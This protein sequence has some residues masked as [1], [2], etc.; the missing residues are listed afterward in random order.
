M[1]VSGHS[2]LDPFSGLRLYMVLEKRFTSEF[3]EKWRQFEKHMTSVKV[4]AGDGDKQSTEGGKTKSEAKP[5]KID[6]NGTRENGKPATNDNGKKEKG[7]PDKPD[8]AGKPGKPGDKGGKH[9]KP[10][11]SGEAFLK[12]DD[13]KEANML[14]ARLLKHRVAAQNLVHMI[15]TQ[16]SYKW[17]DN[18]ANVGSLEDQLRLLDAALTEPMRE[19]LVQDMKHMMDKYTKQWPA[20]L[21]NFKKADMLLQNVVTETKRLL[22]G[23]KTQMQFKSR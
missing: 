5:Q 6:D 16:S 17:A 7:K 11:K 22:A 13:A 14:K 1:G 8:K 2:G 19:F 20:E 4:E 15:H 9:G 10:D 23:H 18:D 3:V 12:S 21:Q